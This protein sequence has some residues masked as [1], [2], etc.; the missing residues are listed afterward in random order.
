MSAK[1]SVMA[2]LVAY[3]VGRAWLVIGVS[4]LLAAGA[5]FYAAGHFKMTT[6]TEQLISANL[7]WRQNG[8]AFA[9]AFPDQ[10][11]SIIA[12]IDGKTPEL[13]ERGAA[14]LAEKIAQRKDLILGVDRPDGGPFWDR[15]GL[16]LLPLSEVKQATEQLIKAQPIL[17]PLAA[18]PSLRGVMNSL[19]TMLMGVQ[20]GDAKLTDIDKPVRSLGQS[21]QSVADGKP[22]F[23]SWQA[24]FSTSATAQARKFVIIRPKLDY[25]A[26]EPGAAASEAIR[27]TAKAAGLDA[28]H[29]ITVR[30]TGNVPLNDEEFASLADRAV[31]MASVMIGAVLLM[32][33]LAVRSTRVTAA[34]M[35]ATLVGLVMTAGLGLAIVGSFN[36][37]S[38][39]FIPL[40]VG[41]G[42]DFGIQFAVKYRADSRILPT[43]DEALIAAAREV[44]ASIALAAAAIAAGFF[45]FLPTPYVGVS[46]LGVIAGVGIVIAFLLTITLLPELLHVLRP[47]IQSA[48]GGFEALAPLDELMNKRRRLVLLLNGLVALVC[49]GLIPFLR[50][51]SNPL[52]LKNPHSESMATLRDL[53]KDPDRSPNTIDVL[54]PSLDAA[55]ALARRLEKLPEVA[56][57]VTLSSFM[58]ADQG[59]KLALIADANLL[60]DPTINPFDIAPPPSDAEL[61]TS[62]R[63]TAADLRAA[64]PSDPGPPGQD[65]LT[66]AAALD[67]LAAG[68]AARRA[69]AQDT[70]VQPLGILLGQLRS[71]LNAQPLTPQTLSPQL[72]RQWTTP[73]GRARVQ[74]FP[75]GGLLDDAGLKHFAKVVRQI[76]PNASGGPVSIVEAGR[77]IVDAFREA[78]VLS[79]VAITVLLLAVLRRVVDV[80]Y[81]VLPV[82]LTGLLTLGT[83]VVI[84]QPIN[85]A[86]IIALPLLFGIGVAFHIYLV[87]AW[88]SGEAHFLT[89]SLTRAVLFSGLTTGIAF[90]ALWISAHPGTASMGKLLLI[91]LAYTLGTAMFFGPALMGPPPKNKAPPLEM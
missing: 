37:I 81:T 12:V 39:A 43:Q 33:W 9:K 59:P 36:L 80:V 64:A 25:S 23:F 24:L 21:L 77:T 69:A 68:D 15:E 56:H 8:I 42:V 52:D 27:Q 29:G 40:F 53:M 10:S 85:F 62:L 26:L 3:S 58:P 73:D 76:A 88:R 82:M 74:V 41:L 46:E 30:L 65:A 57:A 20:R 32:L 71:M 45:A 91:S 83:C 87:M 60:L 63:R 19:Q 18:D 67:K 72:V 2:R 1:P 78:G 22:A 16:V 34:I 51:D 6:D 54:T 5:G 4:L 84:G 17:G 47:R 14:V 86:N 28:A 38:V 79:L 35:G 75:S 50:F 61:V 11:Q 70:V 44:G 7:P 55:N 48:R 31:L 49:V 89:S 66:L 13:A 90:G